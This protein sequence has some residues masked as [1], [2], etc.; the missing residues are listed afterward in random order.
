MNRSQVFIRSAVA[1]SILFVAACG[2]DEEP[3]ASDST[4]VEATTAVE[5]AEATTP[6][7]EPVPTTTEPVE[8][9]APA[10]TTTATTAPP[11][12]EPE[13]ACP[14]PVANETAQPAGLVAALDDAPEGVAVDQS[15]SVFVS[16]I[17]QGELLKFA[18]GSSDFEV[19]GAIPGWEFS[20]TGFLGLAVDEI[21]NVYGAAR[22]GD[23]TGVWKFDC[24]TGDANL[25]SG[26]EQIGF[27]NALAFDGLG[28]LYVSDTWSN[29]DTAAP[30]GAI[31][32]VSS[33]GAVDKWYESETIGGTGAF[34]L[35]APIGAN[36]IAVRDG[37][38]YTAVLERQAIYAIP[39]LDD[40]TAGEISLIVEGGVIPDGIAVD[41][42][43]RVYAA[44]VA[45]SAI[46]RIGLDG[47]VEVVAE[48]APASLDIAT[49]LA[50][51]TGATNLTLYAVN[52]VSIEPFS[53]GIGFGLVAV[54]VDTPGYTPWS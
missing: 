4:V 15:G 29:G 17:E 51:G 27:P 45:A 36:G 9:T 11:T 49:S 31:W 12:T 35:E 28:N 25:V 34:Q 48:G 10:T 3:A 32:R 16:L 7:T 54:D 6:S 47:T 22:A 26:S 43:G 20:E 46:K 41:E 53:T 14:P 19:F 39:V 23:S 2:S 37:M 18:P 5:S 24:R 50:F 8:S 40:G 38:V 30:L 44:D 13:P 1:A 52:L 42:Q 33:D 21:G